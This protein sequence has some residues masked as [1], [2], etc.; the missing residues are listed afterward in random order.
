[1]LFRSP[2]YGT[3][4]YGEAIGQQPPSAPGAPGV[5]GAPIANQYGAVYGGPSELPPSKG[6]AIT[7]LVFS[8]LVCIPI[9]PIVAIVLAIIVL[10]RGR[11]GRNHGKGLAIGALV[12]A[13]LVLLATAGLVGA[14]IYAVSTYKNVDDLQAG[15]CIDGVNGDRTFKELTVVDCAKPHDAQVWA[16][17]VLTDSQARA[18]TTGKNVG[19]RLCASAVT[20][21]RGLAQYLTRQGIEPLLLTDRREPRGGD[22]LACV[23]HRE[24]GSKLTDAIPTDNT[25]STLS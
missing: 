20:P 6:M 23:V 3:P 18:Y 11:D 12:V 17:V 24:D 1:M 21:N 5:P 8:F 16:T 2:Q 15:Q 7:S 13:P 22:H 14:I 25:S 10:R 9:L 4:S 19:D